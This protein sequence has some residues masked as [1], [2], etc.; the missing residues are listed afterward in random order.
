MLA[1]DGERLNGS[2]RSDGD[3]H[4]HGL[5]RGLFLFP[6]QGRGEDQRL[7]VQKFKGLSDLA[8]VVFS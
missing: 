5:L 4:G 2:L 3:F 7:Y 8:H 6:A 1:G